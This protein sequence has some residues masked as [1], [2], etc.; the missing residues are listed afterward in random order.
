MLFAEMTNRVSGKKGGTRTAQEV[1]AKWKD[2]SES[3]SCQ[4]FAKLFLAL[5]RVIDVPCFYV[6]LERDYH[7]RIVYHDCTAIVAEKRVFLVDPNY[8]WFGVPHKE[9]VLLDDIQTVGHHYFQWEHGNSDDVERG[10]VAEKLHPNFA[11]GKVVLGA[12]LFQNGQ[13]AAALQAIDSA[14][15]L[16]RGRWDTAFWRGVIDTCVACN[17]RLH[18]LK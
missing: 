2:S 5:A 15:T 12:A 3:F 8:R 1:F 13:H 17:R 10:R 7:G 16:E 18:I 11:W 4:E 6:H 14:E 9:F